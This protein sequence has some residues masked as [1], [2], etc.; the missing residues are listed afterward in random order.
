PSLLQI[1]AARRFAV[2]LV[3]TRPAITAPSGV[4]SE[5]VK[6]RVPAVIVTGSASGFIAAVEVQ[7]TGRSPAPVTG[8]GL[9]MLLEPTAICP[10][11]E[12]ARTLLAG[13]TPG[14]YPTPLNVLVGVPGGTSESTAAELVTLPSE[15]ARV[16]VYVP[17]LSAPV[18]P[19]R[20]RVALDEPRTTLPSAWVPSH[21][22]TPF[23]RHRR[24]RLVPEAVTENNAREPSTTVCDEGWIGMEGG[25]GI[26]GGFGGGVG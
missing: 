1:A 21:S 9:R 17:S 14:R 10:S 15:F 8:S 18:V 3:L 22:G 6:K 2:G 4:M 5:T 26:G 12:V 19:V 7:S 23:R 16:T 25:A 11:S 20:I 13:A 24:V